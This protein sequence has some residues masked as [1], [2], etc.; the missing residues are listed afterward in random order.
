MATEET[1][2]TIIYANT[3]NGRGKNR[4]GRE[5]GKNCNPASR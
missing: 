5:N 1:R 2:H 3:E 4:M